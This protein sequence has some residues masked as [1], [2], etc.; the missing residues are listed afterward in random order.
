MVPPQQAGPPASI[1][2]QDPTGMP[3]GQSDL[4]IVPQS[5]LSCHMTVSCVNDKANYKELTSTTTVVEHLSA[6]ALG[7]CIHLFT[8]DVTIGLFSL[9][10][11]TFYY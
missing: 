9:K 6:Y 1:N 3:T 2:N 10:Y 11:L 7:T 5:G 8:G 4:Y